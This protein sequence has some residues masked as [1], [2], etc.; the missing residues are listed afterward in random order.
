ML[1]IVS[2]ESNETLENGA[3]TALRHKCFR[4]G[5]GING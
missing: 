1:Y 2:R 3:V 4:L 5:G